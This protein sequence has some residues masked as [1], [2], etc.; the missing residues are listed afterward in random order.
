MYTQYY[1]SIFHLHKCTCV[2]IHEGTHPFPEAHKPHDLQALFLTIFGSCCSFEDAQSHG[3][4]PQGMTMEMLKGSS[5]SRPTPSSGW[6]TLE[7]RNHI[8]LQS[9]LYLSCSVRVFV[10][11]LSTALLQGVNPCAQTGW[12]MADFCASE[13][14][15]SLHRGSWHWLDADINI[16]HPLILG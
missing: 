6:G 12:L 2:A 14:G 13:L 9:H 10:F 8:L 15:S 11:R 5:P 4:S 16:E 1:G 7:R 3:S